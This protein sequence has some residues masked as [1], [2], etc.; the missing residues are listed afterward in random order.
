MALALRSGSDAS[1][2]GNS[3]GDLVVDKPVGT[4]D[5]DIMVN[6]IYWETDT[7]TIS[8]V[9]T[10]WSLA[11]N[12]ANTGA[13]LL[14]VY[15]K[16]ASSEPANYTWGNDTPGN[17]WRNV[18]VAA[19]SGGTG[20]GSLIDVTG[21]SQADGAL[22]A[23]Q[24]APSVTTTGA[25]RML[26]RGGGNFN[27]VP[28]SASGAAGT[29]LRAGNG[30]NLCYGLRASAGATGTTHVIGAG[31]DDYVGIHAAIIS[32]TGGGATTTPPRPLIVRQAVK[33]A[34]SW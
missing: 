8:T 22:E 23:N 26:I 4:V 19:F 9:P 14:S 15:Y 17:Q 7:T 32:D 16:R 20:T 30:A 27:G 13:F 21:S 25:D 33:R 1:F 11:A 18:I 29:F 34:A 24:T 3:G 2:G 6:V 31:S 5:G 10:G 28:T 12:L